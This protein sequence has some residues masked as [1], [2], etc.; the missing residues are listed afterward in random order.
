MP[1]KKV[2]NDEELNKVAGGD[3]GSC[4]SGGIIASNY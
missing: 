4:P 2:L 3:S 1:K